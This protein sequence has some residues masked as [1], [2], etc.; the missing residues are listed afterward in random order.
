MTLSNLCDV[1]V[2]FVG[3]IF[4]KKMLDVTKT[5]AEPNAQRRPIAFDADMSKLQASMTP[6]VSGSR[7]K[8]VFAL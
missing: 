3:M 5:I 8:Y 6:I 2:L 7:E 4:L 1:D